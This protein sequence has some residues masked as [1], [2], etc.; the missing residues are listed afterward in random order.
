MLTQ[1]KPKTYLAHLRDKHL[2]KSELK[3]ILIIAAFSSDGSVTFRGL[4]YNIESEY[5]ESPHRE[6]EGRE[7]QWQ[8]RLK[9]EEE[10]VLESIHFHRYG[11]Y[12]D[13]STDCVVA[14]EKD[15]YLYKNDLLAKFI[16]TQ[17]LNS[18]GKN[19]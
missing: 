5:D 3:N 6:G 10:I 9:Q 1:T 4:E 14:D 2:S 17:L 15:V 7:M 8:I 13:D 16:F 12:S 19:E 11:T 18:G